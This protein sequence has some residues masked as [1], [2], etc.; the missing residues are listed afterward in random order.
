MIQRFL[1]IA[2]ACCA[3]NVQA[4]QRLSLDSC[5]AM[6]LRNNKTLSAS[7]LQ[8]DMAHYKVKAAKT[9]YLPHVS[10][11][12]GYELT[13][14]EISLLSD[15]Q[16]A[17]LSSAGT[18]ATGALHNDLSSA[19]SGL[20]QQGAIS[21]ELA[22]GLG[23]L[24]GQVG[25]K[26]GSVVDGVGQKVVD[27]LHTDTRQIYTV[28]V[29]LTQPI[30]MGGGIIAANRMAK[31]GEEMAANNIE[32]TTQSTL[33]SIDQAYWLVVSVHHKKQLAESYLEVVKKLDNDVQKMIAEGVS[34]RADGLKV[35]VKVNEAEMSLTQAE[36]GLALSKML[37]CQLC[38]LPVENDVHLEDEESA[39]LVATA[40]VENT[41]NSVAMEN[42][43]ELKLL[44]NALDLSRQST[45]LVRAAF[46]PQV[47]LTGGYMA[48]NPNLFNGFERKLS[49]VWNVGVVVRVPLWNWMEGAYK[50]RA[51][52][53]ASS[54][55]QLER[56]EISEKIEL[57]VSQCKFKVN[58]ANR[59]LSLARKNVENAE[60]NLR[61]ANVGFKEG[62]LQTTD[63]MAAQTAWLQAQ[64]QKIDAE[65]DV[66][67]SQVNLKKAL[68]VLQ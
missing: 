29:M 58:E 30:Y 54:I 17:S 25:S 59:R 67:L 37:L 12:G 1:F 38:G 61:C 27:A 15:D 9:K 60:E 18:H 64:S 66:R 62:V 47:I 46:L 36:N 53:I 42:R 3:A 19:L 28:S 31:I 24:F 10:A 40:N 41:D 35:A 26:L 34:T 20:A 16:K 32:A 68:G 14:R 39:D 22:N 2:L 23:N 48:S 56:D 65:I 44:D 5:R 52:K 21:P 45:K 6:A 43:P 55:V 13:S 63:V 7:R 33:H 8:L 49:G 11:L 57:Q 50:V 51:S 4:Q